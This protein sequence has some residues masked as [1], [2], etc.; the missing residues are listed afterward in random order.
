MLQLGPLTSPP[1]ILLGLV[2]LA[3]VLIVGRV[4]LALAWRLV[5]IALVVVAVLWVLGS[6]GP[7]DLL[8]V[9]A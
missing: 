5:I 3:L 6:L 7:G 1:G 8:V 2:A 9:G 4:L